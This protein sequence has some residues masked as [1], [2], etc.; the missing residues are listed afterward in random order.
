MTA[1]LRGPPWPG[2]APRT[3][4]LLRS[5]SVGC[6]PGPRAHLVQPVLSSLDNVPTSEKPTR[7][8]GRQEGDNRVLAAPPSVT[9]GGGSLEGSGRSEGVG[10]RSPGHYALSQAVLSQLPVSHCEPGR[11]PCNA[12]CSL[13]LSWTDSPFGFRRSSNSNFPICQGKDEKA[14]H[15]LI[16]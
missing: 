1:S 6:G 3:A 7:E 10:C 14:T 12:Q 8:R 16:N 2:A 4:L 5:Q 9:A 13:G 15:P 11:S